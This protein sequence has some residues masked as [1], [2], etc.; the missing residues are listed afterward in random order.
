MEKDTR[1]IQ[2][3]ELEILLKIKEV[4]EKYQLRYYLAYGTLIGAIRHKG[5]IP[6]DDDADIWMPAPDYLKFLKVAPKEFGD[7]FFLQTAYTDPGYHYLYGKVMKNNT[8][9]LVVDEKELDIHWGIYVDIFPLV[10]ISDEHE[11]NEEK[12]LIKNA[13]AF[14]QT[15]YRKIINYKLTAKLKML[16][17]V[18]Q[19]IRK[20][21]GNFYMQKLL[22]HF[23]EGDRMMI[24]NH[25]D[26]HYIEYEYDDFFGADRKLLFENTLFSVP[27]NA[28]KILEQNYGDYMTPPPVNERIGHERYCS[29]IIFDC[30]HSYEIY[31]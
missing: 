5:F 9:A 24:L 17:F 7:E 14:I 16:T 23:S 11:L 28:E 15:E 21:I 20:N 31:K 13:V 4:C 27:T 18:P 3:T 30:D 8:A 2:L 1:Q 25:Q 29:A 19:F 6:W 22:S 12:K 10:T 26:F